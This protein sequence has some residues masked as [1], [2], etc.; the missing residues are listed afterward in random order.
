[1]A[2]VGDKLGLYK[3]VARFG[4]LDSKRLASLTGTHERYVRDWLVN[5]AAGGYITYDAQANRY[6]MTPEQTALMADENNP[7]YVAGGFQLF[8]ALVKSEQRALHNIGSGEGMFW[9]EH[10]PG[11]FEGTERFFKPG[12]EQNLVKSWI[13]A[14]NGVEARLKEGVSVAD[15]GCGHGASTIIM[16]KAYPKSHFWGFDFHDSSIKRARQ[17]A[18]QAG[19]ESRTTFEVAGASEFP[20]EE[21]ALITFFDCLHDLADPVGAI[22]QSRSALTPDGTVLIV[23]P[24]ATED[25]A[26]NLNPVGRI[27]SAAS[28]F[29]CMPNA[30]AG[31]GT[32]L[33]TLASEKSL[34]EVVNTGG[35]SHFR[36]VTETP[37]NRI[38]EAKP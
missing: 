6:S 31:G 14:L 3:A 25:V 13:P 38:F 18:R 11:L 21:Y 10:D 27:Y 37:F 23:E 29:V 8:T 12:Y 7:F 4:P 35:L 28:V 19:V 26:G 30:I 5:Q 17:A 2:A 16:A 32:P 20:G 15:V 34:R 1:M 24:M 9:T 22:R 33:G 36:R